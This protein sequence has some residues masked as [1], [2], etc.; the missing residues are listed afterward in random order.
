MLLS[1]EGFGQY[2]HALPKDVAA[3]WRERDAMTLRLKGA[4]NL[5]V[6]G[7]GAHRARVVSLKVNCGVSDRERGELLQWS[8]TPS[9]KQETCEML[10]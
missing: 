8:T 3:W 7:Q 9:M 5:E 1:A 2:W 6:V 4:R 10:P